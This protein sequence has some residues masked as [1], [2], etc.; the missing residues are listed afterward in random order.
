VV[1]HRAVLMGAAGSTVCFVGHYGHLRKFSGSHDG[2]D[3][4]C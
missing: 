3:L 4:V 1:C 2:G